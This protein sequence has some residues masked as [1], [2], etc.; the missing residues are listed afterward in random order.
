MLAKTRTF[1]EGREHLLDW[2]NI[3]TR[4]YPGNSDLLYHIPLPSK[5]TLTRLHKNGW[6]M[7]DNCPTAMKFKRLLHEEISKQARADGIPEN[8]IRVHQADCWHHLQNTWICNTVTVMS[9]HLADVQ[10]EDL[11]HIPTMYRVTMEA[12]SLMIATEKMFWDTSK[13][14]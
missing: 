2:R 13:L 5:L 7:T 8:E 6:L 1:G 9:R 14:R 3:M 10:S 4:M 11:E 12:S